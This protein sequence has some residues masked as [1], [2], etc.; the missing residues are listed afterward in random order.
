[1]QADLLILS[2]RQAAGPLCLPCR[3]E[4]CAGVQGK[5]HGADEVHMSAEQWVAS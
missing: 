1:M 2:R 5:R 4:A 3:H